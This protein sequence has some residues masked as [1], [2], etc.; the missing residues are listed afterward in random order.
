MEAI[1]SAI[2]QV[3][4]RNAELASD[5]QSLESKDS[6]QLRSKIRQ[7]IDEVSKLVKDTR[8]KIQKEPKSAVIERMNKQLAAEN[9]KVQDLANG[10]TRK[11]ARALRA[12]REY[13]EQA[14]PD[15]KR[16]SEASGNKKAQTLEQQQQEQVNL[17]VITREVAELEER[18]EKLKHIEGEV[19]QLAELFKDVAELIS[20]QD[21][22]VATVAANVQAT[23][24]KTVAA[25]AE[26]R[27]AAKHQANGRCVIS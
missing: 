18:E 7:D 8:L 2:E 1:K 22:K 13:I 20:E 9:K 16:Q 26:I 17:E 12:S 21:E 25:E 15:Y 6:T 10:F 3:V 27:E 5:I 19:K 4:K 11:E 14:D 23:K 24:E